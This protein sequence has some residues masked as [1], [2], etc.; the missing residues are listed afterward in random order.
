M[1][2]TYHGIQCLLIQWKKSKKEEAQ[3]DMNVAMSSVY[4]CVCTWANNMA[5][6]KRN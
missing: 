4:V 2:N 3:L 5:L 6:C 1:D